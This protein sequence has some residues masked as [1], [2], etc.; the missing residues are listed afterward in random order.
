M[1]SS[2]FTP[3]IFRDDGAGRDWRPQALPTGKRDRQVRIEQRASSAGRSGYPVEAWTPLIEVWMARRIDWGT[4]REVG[5]QLAAQQSVTWEMPFLDSMDPAVVNVPAARRLVYRSRVYDIVAAQEVGRREAI[6]LLTLVSADLAETPAAAYRAI[7]LADQP[8]AY[9][10]LDETAGSTVNSAAG[11]FVGTVTGGVLRNQPG[12]VAA[13]PAMAF[14]G[15]GYITMPTVPPFLGPFSVEAW[16]KTT[17][18]ARAVIVDHANT[19]GQF[20][21]W[22]LY[23]SSTPGRIH[24]YALTASGGTIFDF[25]SVVGGLNDGLWHH[26]VLTVDLEL[27]RL[28]VDGV[29]A[30]E[31]AASAADLAPS[32][33]PLRLAADRFGTKTLVGA[34]DEVALYPFALSPTQIAAHYNARAAA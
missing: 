3:D 7:V 8:L 16:T 21:G 20:G 24:A 9:W 33:T 32:P 4:E 18:P 22:V 1:P 31:Q 6:R 34:L 10:R 12:A 13:N 28:Y 23:W 2:P 5:A 11:A 30:G 14:D 17:F 15:T 19:S 27:A 29:W 25:D 26:G